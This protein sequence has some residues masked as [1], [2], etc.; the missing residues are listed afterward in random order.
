M[1][2]RIEIKAFAVSRITKLYRTLIG[3][4][5]HNKRLVMDH[6][7]KIGGPHEDKR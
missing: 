5:V 7:N 1:K 4:V 2:L 3:W 6:F